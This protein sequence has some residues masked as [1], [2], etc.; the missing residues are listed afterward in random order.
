MKNFYFLIFLITLLFSGCVKIN[1]PETKPISTKIESLVVSYSGNEQNGGIITF[2]KGKGWLIT[3]TAADKYRGL[4]K[5]YGKI[6]IPALSGDG[7]LIEEGENFRLSQ[8]HMIQFAQMNSR[9][10]TDRR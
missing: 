2:D 5:L 9:W 1:T 6:F 7:G 10:K 3:K 8:E 4:I